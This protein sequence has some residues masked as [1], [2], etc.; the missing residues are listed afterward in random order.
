MTTTQHHA[1]G[2]IYQENGQSFSVDIERRE[3]VT[4]LEHSYVIA[5]NLPFSHFAIED[6]ENPT[7][8]EVCEAVCEWINDYN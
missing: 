4:F 1:F 7:E 2:T 8:E 6:N 5:A 3:V